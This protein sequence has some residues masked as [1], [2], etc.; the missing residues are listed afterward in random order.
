[1][2]TEGAPAIGSGS[3]WGEKRS[4]FAGEILFRVA[5]H[6]PDLIPSLKSPFRRL[7]AWNLPLVN[8]PEL[9]PIVET[10]MSTVREMVVGS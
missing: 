3:I 7:A 5:E 1:M 6:S 4:G 9:V 2:V 8:R 10:I